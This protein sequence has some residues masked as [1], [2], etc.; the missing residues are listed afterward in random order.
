MASA[1]SGPSGLSK[2][3]QMLMSEAIPIT[4]V[5]PIPGDG[6]GQRRRDLV[7]ST[8]EGVSRGGRTDLDGARRRARGASDGE[9]FG[10]PA[11]LS[12][13]GPVTATPGPLAKGP[14]A[15]FVTQSIHQEAM[16][17]GLHIEPWPAAIGAYRRADA[18]PRE[19]L[20]S[21]VSV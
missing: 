1:S 18:G 4:P 13:E 14:T 17:T 8:D 16:G 5:Q 21:D 11:G 2:L 10:L 19:S 9:R 3:R 15:G 12:E 7:E 20:V 6:R